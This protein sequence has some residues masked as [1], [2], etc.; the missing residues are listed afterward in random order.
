MEEQKRRLI[1]ARFFDE[2]ID[3]LAQS[4]GRYQDEKENEPIKEYSVIFEPKVKAIGGQF[5]KMIARPFGFIY[6]L[7]NAEYQISI[8]GSKASYKRIK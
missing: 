1:A 8:S 7:D 6:K 2:I 3:T 4:Y 5:I